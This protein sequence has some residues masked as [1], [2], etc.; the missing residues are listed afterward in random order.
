LFLVNEGIKMLRTKLLGTSLL[1]LFLFSSCLPGAVAS[2]GH[3][4][5]GIPL[6]S[7]GPALTSGRVSDFAF[8]P[9]KWQVHYVAFA[10]GNLWKTVN[11]G[12][13]WTPLFEDEGSYSIGV[14]ELDPSN[15][16]T[17][18]V[19]TG[20]NNSQRSVAFG[21]GVYKSLDGGNSWKNVGLKE[22][23]HISM[24]RI[25]PDDGNTVWVAAQGPLWS[26]GGDRG[27]YKTT[28]GGE[29][30]SKI[31]D[32]D[33]Y[34]R[35]HR[36]QRVRDESVQPGRNRGIQL[37]AQTPCLDP[38]QR[39]AGKRR[40]QDHGRWKDL[41]ENRRGPARRRPRPHWPGVGTD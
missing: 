2:D 36:D 5:A 23:G 29:N 41:A 16:S 18:W 22:S 12:I 40:P 24:I 15:P 8:H 21:D 31:L 25:D 39:W 9:D 17:V 7:I 11:N 33:E 6:R 4:L 38:D 35:K 10:S 26:P 20:E 3:P 1:S 19:G 27:L 30:W 37:P 13:T 34:R 32:I 28:D 14:V